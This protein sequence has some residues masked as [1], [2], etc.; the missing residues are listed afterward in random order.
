MENMKY[1]TILI[2]SAIIGA[3]I[4]KIFLTIE[5]YNEKKNFDKLRRPKKGEIWI[6]TFRTDE[7]DPFKPKDEF[8]IEILD[9]KEGWVRYSIGRLFKDER[10]KL[11][12]FS[13]IYRFYSEAE[14]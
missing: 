11:E 10:M 8:E 12:S 14:K 1:L 6:S 3:L 7:N 5:N 4:V 2:C 9:Y 13:R